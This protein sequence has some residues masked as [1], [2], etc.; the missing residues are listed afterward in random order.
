ME[1]ACNQGCVLL[2]FKIQTDSLCVLCKSLFVGWW[3]DFGQEFHQPWIHV[4]SSQLIIAQAQVCTQEASLPTVF[5]NAV[6]F[7]VCV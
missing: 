7:S 1:S 4:R 5:T 3:K 6:L 2:F